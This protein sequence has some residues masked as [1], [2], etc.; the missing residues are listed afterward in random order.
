MQF[1]GGNLLPRFDFELPNPKIFL[2]EAIANIPSALSTKFHEFK[3]KIDT[4]LAT[5]KAFGKTL[6]DV[7][8]HSQG[9][10]SEQVYNRLT[11][12]LDVVFNRLKDEF[13]LPPPKD[14]DALYQERVVIID[15]LLDG[16][17]GVLVATLPII[18]EDDLKK[19]FSE[20]K[21]HIKDVI[22]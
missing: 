7:V 13:L 14:L 5:S 3:V 16:I 17:E 20:L 2:D 6:E 9:V 19:G 4:L 8:H 18:P 11:E 12:E 15:R 10:T 21:P 1:R 22:L